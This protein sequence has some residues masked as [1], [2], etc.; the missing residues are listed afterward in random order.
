MGRVPQ[1]PQGLEQLRAVLPLQFFKNHKIS[2]KKLRDLVQKLRD[3]KSISCGKFWTN[4]K[5][6]VYNIFE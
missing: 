3:P 1:A 2:L 6:T 5:S 4:S